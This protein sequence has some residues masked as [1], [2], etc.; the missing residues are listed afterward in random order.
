METI[1][2][3]DTSLLI[4]AKTFRFKFSNSITE[5]LLNFSQQYKFNKT[6]E[7]KENWD[8][9]TNENQDEIYREKYR[10]ES[11]GYNG[12]I[13]DK[14]YKSVRYYYCKKNTYSNEI[15]EKRRK[16]ISKNESFINLIDTF[17]K[18]NCNKDNKNEYIVC[19]LKPSDGWAIFNHTYTS[20]IEQEIERVLEYNND[21]S[22]NDIILKIKKTFNN[23]Y[24]INVR[25]QYKYQEDIC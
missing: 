12:D 17:I 4:K 9:W 16:Y 19:N 11:L 6:D 18:N 2:T 22:R 15:K 10:L 3:E 13:I 5:L 24:Y 8:N 14:M 23:R 21:M 25:S 7:F 1:N 20:E